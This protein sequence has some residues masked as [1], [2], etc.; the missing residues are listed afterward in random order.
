MMNMF[1]GK[2]V[3][4]LVFI[5]K[6]T[7]FEKADSVLAYAVRGCIKRGCTEDYE[8]FYG[9][10]VYPSQLES[11]LTECRKYGMRVRVSD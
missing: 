3:T 1:L 11:L 10:K 8:N 9:F 7:K 5:G 6:E 4:V 2:T